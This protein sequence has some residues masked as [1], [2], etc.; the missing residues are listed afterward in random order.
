MRICFNIIRKLS[1]TYFSPSNTHISEVRLMET[2]ILEEEEVKKEPDATLPSEEP[3]L[4]SEPMPTLKQQEEAGLVGESTSEPS[5][6]PEAVGEES[7]EAEASA[8]EPVSE[9]PLTPEQ[10]SVEKMLTQSQ[11][12]EIVGRTRTETRDKTC[13]DFYNRYGVSDEAGMDEVVGRSQKYDLLREDYDGV[14]KELADLKVRLALMDSGIAPERYDDAK[15][16][17]A[18]K[19]LEVTPEN[20]SLELETHPEWKKTFVAEPE[21]E[22]K[23]VFK[24]IE[25][26]PAPAPISKISV[27]GNETAPNQVETPSERESTM[28][29]FR[30]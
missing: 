17:L 1:A 24:K 4:S 26:T 19:G 28:K 9:E 16:I 11:V 18:G 7:V 22:V 27:L 23:E 6:A 5:S 15:F 21:P 30:S 2:K 10:E 14:V 25:E 20:I 29:M 8:T 12:D 3:A 13:K